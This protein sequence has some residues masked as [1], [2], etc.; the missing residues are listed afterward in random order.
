MVHLYCKAPIPL[1]VVLD[2]RSVA[3]GDFNN[4][5]RLDIV[6]ANY[7]ANNIGIFIGYG[8]GSFSS[9]TTYST[10]SGSNP[11]SV[12]VGDLNNDGRPDIAVANYGTSN[13]GVFIGYGN[14]SFTSQKTYSTRGDPIH[15][16]SLLE[17][18][19]TTIDWI[20]SSLIIGATI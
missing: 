16:Q 10:G 9:Q 7:Q 4:D 5:S 6:V 12:T 19:T 14:G 15:N 2:R 8:N 17:I 20:L 11:Y 1:V 18:S 3:I 13:V